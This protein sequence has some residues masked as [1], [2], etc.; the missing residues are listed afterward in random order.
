MNT[1]ATTSSQQHQQEISFYDQDVQLEDPA[2]LAEQ[3]YFDDYDRAMAAAALTA[4]YYDYY[5]DKTINDDNDEMM[6]YDEEYEEEEEGSGQSA[7]DYNNDALL[8]LIVGVQSYL[9]DVSNAGIDRHDSPLLD[10]QYKMYSYLKQRA[11]DM[12][13]ESDLLY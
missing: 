6:D 13:I 11:L 1:S 12:G 2:R 5:N 3:A 9:S 4:D 7:Y 8:S 10:L